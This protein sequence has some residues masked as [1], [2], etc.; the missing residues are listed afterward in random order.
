MNAWAGQPLPI[1]ATAWH[2]GRLA[3]RL[4]GAASAVEAARQ[5]LGGDA[6]DTASALH[7]WQGIRDHRDAYFNGDQPLWR[8]SVKS[9]APPIALPGAQLIEWNGALRWLRSDVSAD[10]IRSAASAAGAAGGHATLFRAHDKSAGVFHPLSPAL[11]TLHRRLK[12]TFDPA[13]ILNSDRLYP[14]M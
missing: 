14:G 1:S 10:A 6:Q 4:S 2:D 11:A 7:Y 9:T 13:G 5:K 8:L 3:I 12:Q